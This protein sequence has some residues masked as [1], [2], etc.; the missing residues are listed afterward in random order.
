MLLV[1]LPE[2]GDTCTGLLEF[3]SAQ[4]KKTDEV[5]HV[6]GTDWVK[7]AEEVLI[8][9]IENL[10]KRQVRTFCDSVSALMSN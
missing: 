9:E 3:S 5:R 6:L 4:K 1:N 7:C 8:E 2:P 10:D